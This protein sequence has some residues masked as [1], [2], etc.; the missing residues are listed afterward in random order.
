MRWMEESMMAW[1]VM[2]RV[3]LDVVASLV[4]AMVRWMPC[5]GYSPMIDLTNNERTDS[6]G[7]CQ[8]T[9]RCGVIADDSI[10]STYQEA[11]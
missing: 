7:S 9:A 2:E 8:E 4:E 3:G 11:S 6:I 10:G 5:F 1:M